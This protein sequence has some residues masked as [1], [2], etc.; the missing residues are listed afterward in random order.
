MNNHLVIGASGLVGGQLLLELEAAGQPV[1]G[2]FFS[3]SLPGLSYLDIQDSEAIQTL[4][5]STRPAVIYLPA[6]LANVDYVE[7]H[8]CESY[9]TNVVGVYNVLRAANQVNARLVY[10]SSDYI[11]DGNEGPYEEEHP[12]NPI[13]NYGRQKLLAE[14]AIGLYSPGC[15]IIR[16][17]VVYG[18]ERQQKN[19]VYRTLHSLQSRQTLAAPIDQVGSPTYAPTLAKAAVW[20]A[21]HGEQGVFHVVGNELANRYEFTLAIAQTFNQDSSLIKPVMT[22]AL[23]Q[24]A[25]RPLKAGMKTDKVRAILPFDLVGYHQGLLVLKEVINEMEQQVS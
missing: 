15:L 1:I 11:F 20:L 17:T 4:L 18:W 6:A 25:S 10:F 22:E 23:N 16:T 3:H 24:K 2:T 13:C 8:S 12:A 7:E 9:Q 21:Q 5:H 14:H 19:F